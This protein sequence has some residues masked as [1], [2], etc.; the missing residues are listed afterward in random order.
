MTT[1]EGSRDGSVRVVHFTDVHVQPER[2]AYEGLLRALA[3]VGALAPKAEA[4]LLGGDVVMNTVG[5]SR[6]RADE[7]WDLWEQ[8]RR[9]YP[10]I[11]IFACVGNQDCWG[12]NRK[13]SGCTG[14]EPLYGKAMAMCRLRL[15][16][17]YYAAD[18]GAWRL[19]VLDSVQPGGKHGFVARLDDD[20]R[21]WLEAELARDSERPTLVMSHVPIVPGPADFFSSDVRGP[22]D[23]GIWPLPGQHLHADAYELVELFRRYPNVKLCLA[24]HMHTRQ[25]IEYAGL[26]F[27][28]SPAVCGAW[29]RGDFLGGAPGYTVLDL[30]P[31]GTFEAE[32]RD[33]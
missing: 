19:L 12:W 6:E 17:L 7:Q 22:S 9:A 13:A 23:A 30:R 15:E 4:I 8:A 14:A 29:W 31:D 11:P 18:L 10:E 33:Y 24:G 20:Q 1:G 27:V 26:W 5:V 16:R 3:S 28:D 25:R 2:G 21:R 32:F